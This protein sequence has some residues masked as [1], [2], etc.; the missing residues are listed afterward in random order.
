MLVKEFTGNGEPTGTGVPPADRLKIPG[1][2][3]VKALA[4]RVVLP[5]PGGPMAA[6]SRKC[7]QIGCVSQYIPP[8]P[9]MTVFLDFPSDQANPNDGEKSA[10]FGC[11]A[12]RPYGTPPVCPSK[13]GE[14]NC[15]SGI[16][17]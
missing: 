7:S 5:S 14:R 17:E 16:L 3:L 4:P 13:I 12:P 8:P 9:R 15:G 10:L 6:P 11:V 2:V 1:I